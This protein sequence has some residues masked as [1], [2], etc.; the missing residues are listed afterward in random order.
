[1]ICWY[2]QP[3]SWSLVIGPFCCWNMV[4]FTFF[5]LSYRTKWYQTRYFWNLL[6]KKGP[7]SRISDLWYCQRFGV[8]FQ[9]YQ[10]RKL[11]FLLNLFHYFWLYIS[12]SVEK[13]PRRNLNSSESHNLLG[14][15]TYSF[16]I[17][18]RGNIK[19]WTIWSD[20]KCAKMLALFR[21]FLITDYVFILAYSI[22]F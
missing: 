17:L 3:C 5:S 13:E 2:V 12:G 22:P 14:S 7:H 18:S 16:E 21:K 20:S 4:D 6:S 15:T 8:D 1:M 9:S 10:L 11:A 19:A